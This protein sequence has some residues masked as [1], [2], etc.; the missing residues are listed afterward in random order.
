[1]SKIIIVF[2]LFHFYSFIQRIVISEHRTHR[3][4][5]TPLNR[6]KPDGN[7]PRMLISLSFLYEHHH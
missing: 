3:E 6:G 5:L 7:L 1:M 4:R 2:G